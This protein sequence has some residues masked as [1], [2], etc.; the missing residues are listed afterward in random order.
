M[1]PGVM[2]YELETHFQYAMKMN[3]G[4]EYAFDPIIASGKNAVFLH[5]GENNCQIKED[6]LVLI[7]IGA[8]Y[9]YYSSDISRT[10]PSSG[11]F[12]DRQAQVY[13]AVLEAEEEIIR[14]LKPGFKIDFMRNIAD[15]ILANKCIEMGLITSKE[16]I[17]KYL[18]HGVGH[19]MGLDTHDVG[20]RDILV[21][22]MVVTV[23]PGLYIREEGIGVRIEDDV[24]ITEDGHDVLSKDIIKSTQGYRT[25][26]EN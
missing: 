19:Y 9:D 12:T 18:F 26:H 11:K 13:S 6:E 3:G 24:L 22:G 23:E 7:D 4:K 1:K 21:P 14:A 16:E 8:E 15:E 17:I 25:I 20:D 5:Y 2:E 10:Y